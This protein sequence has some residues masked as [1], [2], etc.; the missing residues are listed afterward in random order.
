MKIK[1]ILIVACIGMMFAAC[2]NHSEE[3]YSLDSTKEIKLT[4]NIS[5]LST[6]ATDDADLLQNTAFQDGELINIYMTK[7]SPKWEDVDVYDYNRKLNSNTAGSTKF[8]FTTNGGV[9]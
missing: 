8:Q 4:A 7:S 1:S 9:L 6:R 2:S 3:E 5:N